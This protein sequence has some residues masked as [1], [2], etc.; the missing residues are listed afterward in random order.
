MIQNNIIKIDEEKLK[1]WDTFIDSATDTASSEV[2][3]GIPINWVGVTNVRVPVSIQS[4]E[5]KLLASINVGCN[6]NS[7]QRGL[8]MSRFIEGIFEVIK[9]TNT[10]I[11]DIASKIALKGANFN[12]ASKGNSKIIAEGFVYSTTSQSKKDSTEPVQL[13]AE[14]TF[15]KKKIY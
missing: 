13:F 5:N 3:V 6:L 9:E 10:H 11:V 15:I 1:N 12:N 14:S 8:H 2:S 4:F 7:H